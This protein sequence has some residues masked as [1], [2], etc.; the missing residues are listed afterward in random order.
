[1]TVMLARTTRMRLLESIHADLP[2]LHRE[3]KHLGRV[4]TQ[5]GTKGGRS[6]ASA[7]RWII[8]NEEV[9]AALQ[10]AREYRQPAAATYCTKQKA[11]PRSCNGRLSPPA[12]FCVGTN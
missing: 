2:R 7:P 8:A 11:M 5:E 9:N 10:M 4:N 12:K 6:G 3:A 1:M